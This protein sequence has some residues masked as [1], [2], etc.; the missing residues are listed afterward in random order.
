MIKTIHRADQHRLV[1]IREQR[2]AQ[3]ISGRDQRRDKLARGLEA[4][5][6]REE[7]RRVGHLAPCES[8]P[9]ATENENT[10]AHFSG[11]RC[12]SVGIYSIFLLGHGPGKVARTFVP[13]SPH[14]RGSAV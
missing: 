11:T 14:P 8:L 3:G 1:E 7:G 6:M 12:C 4:E 2:L 13:L 5:I 9:T 10:A